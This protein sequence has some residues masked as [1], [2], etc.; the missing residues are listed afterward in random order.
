MFRTLQILMIG[1]MLIFSGCHQKGNLNTFPKDQ[2]TADSIS[3]TISDPVPQYPIFPGG[4]DALLCYLE[5]SYDYSILNRL[6]LDGKMIIKFRIDTLGK[7]TNIHMINDTVYKNGR[8]IC[9]YDKDVEQMMIRI[10][11]KM[12][13]WEPGKA[14]G[15]KVSVIYTLPITSPYTTFH[16]KINDKNKGKEKNILP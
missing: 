13:Q 15:K 3:D 2:I 9:T 10:I 8:V 12:P 11:S 7:T 6:D 16:C 14:S 1:L 4:D 5:R